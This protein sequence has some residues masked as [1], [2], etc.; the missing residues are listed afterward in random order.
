MFC[1]DKSRT[2][3]MKTQRF[4][5]RE[6]FQSLL[7]ELSREGYEIMGPQVCEHAVT[8]APLSRVEQLPVGIRD[9]QSPGNYRLEQ[10]GS[11]RCFDWAVGPMAIKPI[12]F[13]GREALWHS[14]P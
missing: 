7:D 1:Y 3:F 8:F 11:Q 10:T 4:L 5:P 12:T 9:T 6:R 2:A 14:E 13:P